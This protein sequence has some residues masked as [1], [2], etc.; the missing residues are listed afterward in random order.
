MHQTLRPSRKAEHAL[1]G[2]LLDR[3]GPGSELIVAERVDVRPT[4]QI[5][6]RLF[7][8]DHD[9]ARLHPWDIELVRSAEFAE[10]QQR[11]RDPSPGQL[12]GEV[13]EQDQCVQRDERLRGVGHR[14]MRST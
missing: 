4:R 5:G 1:A 9:V 14:T 11:V 8:G 12:A 6:Q 13:I 7:V 3:I 2:L 10:R